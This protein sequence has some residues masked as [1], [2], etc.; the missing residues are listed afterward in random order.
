MVGGALDR[1]FLLGEPEQRPA[2]VAPARVAKGEME[3]TGR[4]RRTICGGSIFGEDEQGRALSCG[5]KR[6]SRSNSLNSLEPEHV[7]V[8]TKRPLKVAGAQM[9]ADDSSLSR[10]TI[11]Q[12]RGAGCLTRGLAPTCSCCFH[13]WATY[14]RLGGRG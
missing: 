4:A 11:R 12:A 3:K 8:E 2:K 10:Q 1:I 13:H 9:K 7:A 6:G 14:P 5:R